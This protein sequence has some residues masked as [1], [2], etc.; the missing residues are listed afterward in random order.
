MDC[1][2]IHC[3]MQIKKTKL[4]AYKTL[5]RPLLE[6]AS[7]SWDPYL[8]KDIDA[9]EMVQRRAVRFISELKGTV[10]ISDE[11]DKLD[12]DTLECRRRDFRM[13]TMLKLLENLCIPFWLISLTICSRLI[14][15]FV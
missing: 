10:S 11:T 7:A 4:I 12:L 1:S 15:L 8:V 2:N 5:C 3:F 14:I 9:L 6:Y 13:S